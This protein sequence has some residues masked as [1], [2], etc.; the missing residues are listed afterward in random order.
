MKLSIGLIAAGAVFLLGTRIAV[1]AGAARSVVVGDALGPGFV[2]VFV[3]ALVGLCLSLAGL[4]AA[5]PTV[6]GWDRGRAALAVASGILALFGLGNL[7]Y[8]WRLLM[9]QT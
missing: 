5:S 6:R 4:A 7:I 2:R 3:A 9:S 8:M 1:M